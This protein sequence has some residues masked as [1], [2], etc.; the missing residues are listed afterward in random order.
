MQ[1]NGLKTC[2]RQGPQIQA[3]TCKYNHDTCKLH[4]NTCQ[5]KNL[6]DHRFLARHECIEPVLACI[7]MYI[8]YI[9]KKN[10]Y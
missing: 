10:T 4:A 1:Y 9:Q 2:G 8:A 3:N 6:D 5:Y 7:S